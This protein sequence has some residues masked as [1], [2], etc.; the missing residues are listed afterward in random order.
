MPFH[1]LIAVVQFQAPDRLASIGPRPA[2]IDGRNGSG[3][4]EAN[5]LAQRIGAEAPPAAYGAVNLPHSR[6][7]LEGDL[8]PSTDS[9]TI[10]FDA[11]QF[12]LHPT[13]G[14]AR[15]KK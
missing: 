14:V 1:D 6:R 12:Q 5:F 4:S 15:I 7:C 13:V 9:R 8:N 11:R 10:C 2:D 3:V